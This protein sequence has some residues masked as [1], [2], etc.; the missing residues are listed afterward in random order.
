MQWP[1]CEFTESTQSPEVLK[2]TW[3]NHIPTSEFLAFVSTVFFVLFFI[4]KYIIK[5]LPCV[6][7]HSRHVAPA[8]RHRM[9]QTNGKQ[10]M[11]PCSAHWEWIIVT[12]V[13]KTNWHK[14]TLVPR[15]NSMVFNEGAIRSESNV[16]GRTL[17]DG[18]D[19]SSQLTLKSN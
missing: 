8:K 7:R 13:F 11:G 9:T 2:C 5:C 15:V 12:R 10:T 1:F 4:H 6:E 17:E 18:N 3:A 19:Y 16:R 14:H